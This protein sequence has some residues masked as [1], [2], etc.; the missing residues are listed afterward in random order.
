M[1]V[2]GQNKL[3]VNIFGIR[4]VTSLNKS[5]RAKEGEKYFLHK[6]GHEEFIFGD[7]EIYRT[8]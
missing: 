7:N 1:A 3:L 5:R 6:L 8:R 4:F 2:L